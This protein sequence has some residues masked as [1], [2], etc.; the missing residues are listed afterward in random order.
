MSHSPAPE[1]GRADVLIVGA[2]LA[3]LSAAVRAAELGLVP[4][5]LE[6][7]AVQRYPSN[8]RY[9]GAVF[10]LGFRSMRD[11]PAEL[12]RWLVTATDGFVRPELAA[13]MA[14]NAGRSINWLIGQ[15]IEFGRGETNDGWHDLVAMPRG[16]HGRP[17]LR[18]E[19]LG[20]DRMLDSLEEALERRGARI[21]RGVRVAALSFAD[22]RCCGVRTSDG[23]EMR[24]RAVILANGGFESNDELLRRYVTAFPERMRQ[25]GPGIGRG[26][27]L[28]MAAEA[29]AEL[30]GMEAF[31]GHTLSADARHNDKLWPFPFLDFLAASG[32]LV[33]RN[34]ARFTDEGKG[35][36][37]MANAVARHPEADPFFAVFDAAI[38]DETGRLLFSPTN[39]NLVKHG[40]TLHR[41][42]TLDEL[43][44][45]A[46]LSAQALRQTVEQHNA[47]VAS[48]DFS[49]LTPLRTNAK[50]NARSVATPPFYAAP[51][52]VGITHTM[53]GV[54]IDAQGR[55]LAKDGSVIPGLFAAGNIA[56]G[57]DGGPQAYYA[58]G[59]AQA[60]IFGLLA[61]EAIA[62]A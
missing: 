35:G 51:G 61:A 1:G 53:G 21:G 41:A 22:G 4:L 15:G 34:A 49:I 12:A 10:H 50:N 32:V 57:L 13:V 45:A 2:G 38:W 9:S 62:A 48:G 42:D 29:G 46:G 43:A 40:G 3:G 19:G 6:A 27:G 36:V 60:L 47:A 18:W 26:D 25:R 55:V 37:P 23:R 59:L 11:D 5:L 8:T 7:G 30:I 28:I 58:G 20:A 17:G 14:D 16:S 31:Y 56:G 39:P 24:A 44:A 54:R 33:D 52:C